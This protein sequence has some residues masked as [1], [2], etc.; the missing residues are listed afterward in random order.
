[1]TCW[2]GV[3][4]VAL[5]GALA[6]VAAAG[7]PD[8]MA[9]LDEALKAVTATDYGRDAR[10]LEAVEAAVVAAGRD[11]AQRGAVEQRLLRG[12]G[13]AAPRATRVFL[14]KQLRTVATAR[15]IPA[16]SGMLNDPELSHM[17]RYVLG[18]MEG[19]AGLAALHRALPAASGALQ[20]GIVATLAD[21][22]YAKALPD[23][24]KLL[25]SPDATVAQT[26][27]EA[28][29]R[30]GGAEAAKALQAARSGASAALRR[31]IDD[32]LLKCAERLLRDGQKADAARIYQLFYSAREPR[33]VRIGALGGLVAA[34][35]AE[36][37]PLL[38]Q[39]IRS[40]DAE[41][42][43][44]AIALLPMAKGRAATEAFVALLPSL[45]PE[46]QE[47]V[48]RA[49]GARGDAAAADAVVRATKS[50]HAAVRLAALEA[51]GGVG[52][53]P[54]AGLLARA[55][56]TAQGAEQQVA[57]ASLR[58]LGGRDVD[59]TLLRS[60]GS[61]DAKVRIEMLRALAGRRARQ[62]F[63]KLLD[64]ARDDDESVRREAIR[65]LGALA[66]EADLPALLD[67]AARPKEPGD[68]AAIEQ[69]VS[70]V[71]IQIRRPDDRAAPLLAALRGA[72]VEARPALVRLLAVAGTPR[73]LF[74]VRAALKDDS[75]AVREAAVRTLANWP[76]A[77]PAEELLSLARAATD[78][79]HKVLL[80]RGYVRMAGMSKDPTGMYA[81]AMRF[82]ERPDDK[83]LVLAGLGT[84]SSAGAL[85]LVEAYL[86][87]ERLAAEAGLAAVQ[88][89]GR[90][91]QKDAARAR[92]ALKKVLATVRNARVRRQAQDVLNDMDKYEGYVLSWTGSGPYRQK[93]KGGM[94]LFDVAFPPEQPGAKGVKW[95]RLTR[96]VGS[97][98]VNLE[99]AIAGGDH[100]AGYVRTRVWSPA[101]QDARLELGSDDSV[102][103][104]LNGKLVHANKVNRGVEPRQ[105]LANV[106]LREGWNDL[107]L[108]VTDNEGG[109]AFC[110]RVRT[111]DGS[112]L[113][114]LKVQAP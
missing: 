18:R 29:G 8:E 72:P 15:S 3:F 77:S 63:A 42:R 13:A 26:A 83:K 28:A 19:P 110:C 82:A 9:R 104:W 45:E 23:V 105:D 10:S 31:R 93:G 33:H 21:R 114:G 50:P 103:V 47:L 108:K 36:A 35:G 51:L 99:A 81:R 61:G 44:S 41:L 107:M 80:L 79:T 6:A 25:G 78:E 106:S 75:A 5:A 34:R 38:V 52:G 37:A 102:K 95:T 43:A 84:T 101:Q 87:D 66:G 100:C 74:A 32:G 89:A 11:P 4:L 69:A 14:C 97:W 48:L 22:R 2:R 92:A 76:N 64:V 27:A 109:W 62:A 86:T 56:A 70:W 30:I 12:L 90:L 96:G 17:A 7:E 67:L 71:L 94:D 111:R 58:R 55:A 40:G 39:A 85:T 16:L 54:A 24:V 65:T 112:A 53:A 60:V 20:A 113:D 91:R 49:L 88:I 73:A 46:G 59:A 1:M 68:R 98:E 57:R